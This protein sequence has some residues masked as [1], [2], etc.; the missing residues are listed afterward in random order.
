MLREHAVIYYTD[1]KHIPF[2]VDEDDL[3]AVSRYCWYIGDVGYPTTNTGKWP[4]QRTAVRL[5]QF[6][7][8]PA[9]PG[10]EW[11]H[12][13]RDKLDNRRANLRA[14]S[15]R[16][17]TRNTG[18]RSDNTSGVRGVT[19]NRPTKR[20]RAQI[21]AATGY[22]HLGMFDSKQDAIAARQAAERTLWKTQS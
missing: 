3:D 16:G 1:K 19:W 4:H 22:R 11:D 13:N 10:L 5:H 20:W 18:P 6:L 14:V 15:R 17:N 2:Q 7:L 21:G 9:G 8:G 12:I